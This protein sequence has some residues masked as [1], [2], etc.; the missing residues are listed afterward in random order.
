VI[1]RFIRSIRSGGASWKIGPNSLH[2]LGIKAPD[3]SQCRVVVNGLIVRSVSRR[4]LLDA[5]CRS[6]RS[7]SSHWRSILTWSIFIRSRCWWTPAISFGGNADQAANSH[8]WWWRPNSSCCQFGGDWFPSRSVSIG[9]PASSL[10]QICCMASWIQ[11][12][13]CVESMQG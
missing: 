4:G 10:D 1:G 7:A 6:M 5:S 2:H 3:W 12:S 9:S 13:S 8:V 11:F